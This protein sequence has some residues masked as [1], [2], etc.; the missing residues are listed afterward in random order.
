MNHLRFVDYRYIRFSFHPLKDIFVLCNSWKDPTWTDVRS[1]RAG[2]DGEEKERRQRLFGKNIISIEEKSVPQ[3][4]VDEVGSHPD[5][6]NTRLLMKKGVSS[7]LRVP[8]CQL[9]PV[10][11]RSVL[12]LCGLHL[13]HICCQHYDYVAR[14]THGKLIP[15]YGCILLITRPC[16]AFGSCQDMIAMCESCGTGF[17]SLYLWKHDGCLPTL[18]AI[19]NFQRAGP[20]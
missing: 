5:A 17:V 9:N 2:L 20:W 4:L 6:S 15:T 1:I 18:R 10:V 13:H 7:F 14:D 11:T 16:D 12:L 19:Y 3:L 8:N